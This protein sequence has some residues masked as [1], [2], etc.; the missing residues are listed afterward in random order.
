MTRNIRI[1]LIAVAALAILATW[2]FRP[3]WSQQLVLR[4]CFNDVRGLRSGAGVRIAGVDVGRVAKVR[5]R[6]DNKL[7]PADV[8]M[9]LNTQYEL[10]VPTDAIAR[11]QSAG[12]LGE[13]FVDIG[14]Q[15]AKGPPATNDSVL[16]T[17]PTKSPVEELKAL[18]M[19]LNPQVPRAETKST[20]P[21]GGPK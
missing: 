13:E 17:E 4:A 9:K 8:E 5:A 21:V 14:V 16:P 10:K 6:P 1:G 18:I 3:S 15:D 20:K 12:L 2:M 19:A 11:V 7:C